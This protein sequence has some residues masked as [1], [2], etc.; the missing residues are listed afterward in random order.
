MRSPRV[1][2]VPTDCFF[3]AMGSTRSLSLI[4][5]SRSIFRTRA[6]PGVIVPDS[7][8]AITLTFSLIFAPRSACFQ[9]RSSRARRIFAGKSSASSSVPACAYTSRGVRRRCLAWS[10]SAI[11]GGMEVRRTTGVMTSSPNFAQFAQTAR[12]VPS[13]A[14]FLVRGTSAPHNSQINE[15]SPQ[16]LSKPSWLYSLRRTTR[17]A[18]DS[19]DEDEIRE[20]SE[21]LSGRIASLEERNDKLLEVARK[22]ESEK[23]YVETE[24]GRLQKEIKRLKQE[25][26]RLKSQPL[27]IGNIRDVLADGRVVVKSS[28]GPDF[29][30]HAADYISKE[31][32]V[33]G[34][35]VALNKQTL[36]VMGVLPPSLDPIV[37]G[38]EIIEKPECTYEDIGGLEPQMLE[39]REA[40]EDPLLK[41]ELYRKVGIEPPKGV[42]LVGPPG[43]GK[44]LI[45]KAVANRTKATFIRF[46]GSE[47]VQKY[48]G[49]GARLVRELFQLAREKAPSIVFI[50]ELDSVGAKR[51]EVAT[52][53][54]REVQRTLMQLL[55][56]LDGFNPLGEVKIVGAT[57]R[58][59]IL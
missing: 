1:R 33:V 58:P 4:P 45:A 23:R 13:I 27:I 6:S 51:L 31:N 7:S 41:P 26:D 50:D 11:T 49:E 17:A 29:I 52:S 18:C 2:A 35:R 57:N 36:A 40:V 39:L 3:V 14:M 37:T 30:V 54:D 38:A 34:A 10:R 44:T 9:P 56:E 55:A 46:V 28:T 42:L 19:M 16:E 8:F 12:T 21:K 48:I 47:L 15:S 22:V 5:S 20:F 59:D 25:L 43:T 32:I 53:G 24:V